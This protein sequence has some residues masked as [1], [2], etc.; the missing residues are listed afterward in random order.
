MNKV[1]INGIIL[2][3]SENMIP[4]KD[5]VIFVDGE[6]ISRIERT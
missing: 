4:Q 2:D 3:G 5:M 6:K 1:Y